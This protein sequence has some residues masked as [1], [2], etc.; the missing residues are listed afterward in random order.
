MLY[1]VKMKGKLFFMITPL[2]RSSFSG[3][4]CAKFEKAIENPG[5][6]WYNISVNILG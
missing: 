4:F 1:F 5:K 3:K 2:V 6:M